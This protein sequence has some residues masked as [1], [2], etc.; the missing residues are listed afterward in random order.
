[1]LWLKDEGR[2]EVDSFCAQGSQAVGRP[3]KQSYLGQAGLPGF[4]TGWAKLKA[5][6]GRNGSTL[7]A[8]RVPG[9]PAGKLGSLL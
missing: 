1:M 6:C 4:K 5:S 7:S 9:F 3:C 2:M 8:I